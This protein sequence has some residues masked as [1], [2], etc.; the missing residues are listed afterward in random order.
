MDLVDCACY[1]CGRLVPVPK[2]DPS[3]RLYCGKCTRATFEKKPAITKCK[4]L[5]DEVGRTQCASCK[6]LVEIKLFACGKGGVCTLARKPI[7]EE[8]KVCP[9]EEW[10]G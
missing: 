4:H 1:R 10:E 2:C 9:C 7:K 3:R 5:G 8:A 6:G